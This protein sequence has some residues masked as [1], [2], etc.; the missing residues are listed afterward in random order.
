MS[1]H[2]IVFENVNRA[3]L[4]ISENVHWYSRA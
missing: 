4:E 3:S 1:I 2:K